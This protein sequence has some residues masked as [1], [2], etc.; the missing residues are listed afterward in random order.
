MEVQFSLADKIIPVEVY[1]KVYKLSNLIAD[2]GGYMGLLLGASF[3]SLYKAFIKF[4]QSKGLC[5]LTGRKG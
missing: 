5:H 3:L 2:I 4:L 1:T